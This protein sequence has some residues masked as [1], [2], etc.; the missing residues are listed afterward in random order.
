MSFFH[1]NKDQ[2]HTFLLF[3]SMSSLSDAKGHFTVPKDYYLQHS[4]TWCF[5]FSRRV[6]KLLKSH[7]IVYSHSCHYPVSQSSNSKLNAQADYKIILRK[8][9][10]GPK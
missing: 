5:S 6:T 7:L 4:K 2:H 9:R 10:Y 1:K 8:S 3:W